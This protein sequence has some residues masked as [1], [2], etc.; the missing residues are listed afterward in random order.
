MS[1][2]YEFCHF[3]KQHNIDL[4][5]YYSIFGLYPEIFPNSPEEELKKFI[6]FW[7]DTQR[8]EHISYADLN[9]EKEKIGNSIFAALLQWRCDSNHEHDT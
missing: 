8:K 7:D 2:E 6:T 4:K 5:K 1:D 3:I 9:Q